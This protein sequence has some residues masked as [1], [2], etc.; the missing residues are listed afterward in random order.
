MHVHT[1]RP[2]DLAKGL[3]NLSVGPVS[4]PLAASPVIRSQSSSNKSD[5]WINYTPHTQYP[6]VKNLPPYKRKRVL[7]T[8][9]AGFVGSHL[10]DRLMFLG[11]E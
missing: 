7:V 10:V 3:S 1:V 4:H 8:G 9:G 5:G 6:P 2:A 11:H